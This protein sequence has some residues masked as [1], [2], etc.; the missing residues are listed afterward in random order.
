MLFW[1]T[2]STMISLAS[3]K[4]CFII[5]ATPAPIPPPPISRKTWVGGC[6]VSVRKSG[7]FQSPR[8]GELRLEA[9]TE[10]I[11]IHNKKKARCEASTE[12]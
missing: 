11:T 8:N 12:P 5:A 3:G 7:G 4:R 10:R 9:T 6:S 1:S 2:A